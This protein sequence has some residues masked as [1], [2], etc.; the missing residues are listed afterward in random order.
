MG[1]FRLLFACAPA[2]AWTEE[3]A[4]APVLAR[5]DGDR[6]GEVTRAEFDA[7]AVPGTPFAAWDTDRDGVLSRDEAFALWRE[8]DPV[9]FHPFP[10]GPPDRPFHVEE[11]DPAYEVLVSLREE[12]LA[13]DPSAPVPSEA[14]LRAASAG[15]LES[16]GAKAALRTLAV[17]SDAAGVAFPPSL[18]D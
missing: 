7:V 3:A 5:L 8:Q 15:G 10:T 14:A 17:V 6:D 2:T 18:R 1:T 9:N 4:L 11:H 12:V 16:E 13:K